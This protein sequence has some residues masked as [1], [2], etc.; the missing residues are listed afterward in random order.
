MLDYQPHKHTNMKLSALALLLLICCGLAATAQTPGY[1]EPKLLVPNRMEFGGMQLRL[2]DDYQKVVQDEVDK[3]MANNKYFRASVE[4]ADAY[5]HMVDRILAEEDVPQDLKYLVL[6]ESKLVSD[7]VSTSNAVGFWQFKKETGVEMGLRVDN[8]VDERM[9]IVASTRAAARYMKKHNGYMNNWLYAV[10]SYYAGLTGAKGIIDQKYLGASRMDLDLNTHWYITK[11]LAHKAAYEPSINRN[12]NMPYRV[13]EYDQCENKTLQQIALE[14]SVD[15]EELKFYN[16]W[17]RD[18][19]V[20][21]DKDYVVLIPVKYADS[22]GLLA[23]QNQPATDPSADLKPY[24]KTYFFGLIES[25]EPSATPAPAAAAQVATA[26]PV[27]TGTVD[28]YSN[29]PLLFQ[30]NGIK[31]I[32]AR[33]SDN[34]SRLALQ[35]GVSRDAFLRYNDMRV[36]DLVVPGQVYYIKAKKKK[37]RVP[38]HIVKENETLWEV[39]QQYGIA[40]KHLLKKNRMD[41]PELLK[42]GRVLWLRTVRPEHRA[43]EYVELPKK[44]FAPSFKPATAPVDTASPQPVLQKMADS[45]QVNT[46][47]QPHDEASEDSTEDDNT[48]GI[49]IHITEE[50]QPEG[51]AFLTD[52]AENAQVLDQIVKAKKAGLPTAV[53]QKP[54]PSAQQQVIEP[55]KQPVLTASASQMGGQL[56]QPSSKP[57]NPAPAQQLVASTDKHLKGPAPETLEVRQPSTQQLYGME[58]FDQNDPAFK[59]KYHQLQAGQT[60]YGLSRMYN[61]PVDSLLAWN[62][63]TPANLKVGMQLRYKDLAATQSDAP[64]QSAAPATSQTPAPVKTAPAPSGTIPPASATP[65]AARPAEPVQQMMLMED[66][67]IVITPKGTTAPAGKTKLPMKSA[68]VQTAKPIAPAPQPTTAA[69]PVVP[70]TQ[71]VLGMVEYEVKPGDTLWRI[72]KNHNVSVE[73]VLSWN[74]EAAQGIKPGDK[75]VIKN[76]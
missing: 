21:G 49:A 7:V 6:Q 68:P 30:W 42:P 36:F 57:A 10:L 56:Q 53:A 47:P 55:V 52:S 24:K 74:K 59:W 62:N 48:A 64:A 5:F 51:D 65:A 17:A 20:P 75:L 16:K 66:E 58:D 31:A 9:N 4:R 27:P 29:V 44:E 67:E 22:P 12:P 35:A 61:V 8:L 25:K 33:K 39:S 45:L 15:Y 3:L 71:P 54:T 69:P 63:V 40:M 72:A 28:Y 50:P 11:F 26:E 70:A 73:Q 18:G 76:Q 32:M 34:I 46:H 60:L 23:L 41:K 43:V 38:F 14:T 13:M 2:S 37:A 19:E 1:N